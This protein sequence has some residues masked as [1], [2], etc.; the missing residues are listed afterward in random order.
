MGLSQRGKTDTC[1]TDY[2]QCGGSPRPKA[3]RGS[4]WSC[5]VKWCKSVTLVVSVVSH[6]TSWDS[7]LKD[8]SLWSVQVKLNQDERPSSAAR[9]AIDR[10][11]VRSVGSSTSAQ[12]D[13]GLDRPV[14][15]SVKL[16]EGTTT[17][18][19]R[20]GAHQGVVLSPM[21]FQPAGGGAQKQLRRTRSVVYGCKRV[22]YWMDRRLQCF[23]GPDYCATT[24]LGLTFELTTATMGNPG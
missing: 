5:P 17:I 19:P 12:G 1:A 4:G 20:G 14:I 9:A 24:T 11:V 16:K 10:S 8:W 21:R 3:E 6:I 2:Q 15:A 13:A 18:L 7:T 23:V 22:P